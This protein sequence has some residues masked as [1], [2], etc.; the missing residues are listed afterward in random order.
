MKNS[1]TTLMELTHAYRSILKK[2]F[3]LNLG[4]VFFAGAAQAL[5]VEN[6]SHTIRNNYSY[7][8][9]NITLNNGTLNILSTLEG[10]GSG[11]QG[12]NFTLSGNTVLNL[13][14]QGPD[15]NVGLFGNNMTISGNSTW[16]FVVTGQDSY[17]NLFMCVNP[18]VWYGM[19]DHFVNLTNG[20]TWTINTEMGD[21]SD[22]HLDTNSLNLGQNSTLRATITRGD[23]H[24][25]FF[26][27]YFN[28]DQ[29]TID[30]DFTNI[31]PEQADIQNSLVKLNDAE[32]SVQTHQL[33]IP[34]T[35]NVQDSTVDLNYSDLSIEASG[36]KFYATMDEEDQQEFLDDMKRHI[37]ENDI[38]PWLAEV[39]Q[40]FD[41]KLADNITLHYD[42]I[43]NVTWTENGQSTSY[44][45]NGNEEDEED[46]SYKLRTYLQGIRKNAT[47]LKKL[48]DYLASAFRKVEGD[49]TLSG[50]TLTAKYASEIT[51]EV[52][53]RLDII[54][55][56]NITLNKGKA[57]TS[58]LS[59]QGTTGDIYVGDS[60]ITLN[61][62]TSIIRGL[63]RWTFKGVTVNPGVETSYGDVTF[64]HSKLNMYGTSFLALS[65]TDGAVRFQN[66][67]ELNIYGQNTFY[68]KNTAKASDGAGSVFIGFNEEGE[69]EN[70]VSKLNIEKGASL[71]LVTGNV[72]YKDE[73]ETYAPII[74]GD[75]NSQINIA[76]TL[77]GS[78]STEGSLKLTS[79][80]KINGQ[81]EK[82]PHI[83]LEGH[84]TDLK[85]ILGS[86]VADNESLSLS[87]VG[88]KYTLNNAIF[89]VSD[90]NETARYTE[91]VY[92]PGYRQVAFPE[93]LNMYSEED[94][95]I[96]GNSICVMGG[97]MCYTPVDNQLNTLTMTDGAALSTNKM[98]YV[99]D[100]S[101]DNKASFSTTNLFGAE[102]LTL[103]GESKVVLNAT[104]V[105]YRLDNISVNGNSEL[106]LSNGDYYLWNG[107]P[108]E[109]ALDVNNSTLTTKNTYISILSGSVSLNDVKWVD[110][111]SD[112]DIISSDATMDI[113]GD[114]N[115]TLN[116]TKA[117]VENLTVSNVD[118]K[119]P[120][121]TLNNGTTLSGQVF[122]LTNS[123]LVANNATFGVQPIGL[124]T[125][126]MY[127]D[128]TPVL[129]NSYN[130]SEAVEGIEIQ[131]S[132]VTL[133]GSSSLK[134][135]LIYV[136]EGRKITYIDLSP[137]YM[138][139]NRENLEESLDEYS[140]MDGYDDFANNI[141]INN[142]TVVLNGTASIINNSI[143][144]A[145]GKG[146]IQV[147][148]DSVI[149]A[150][151]KNTLTATGSIR[152]TDNSTLS[153][154]NGAVLNVKS[155]WDYEQ[156]TYTDDTIHL[157][158]ANLELSGT[159]NGSLDGWAKNITLSSNF[160]ING[161]INLNPESPIYGF[162][163]SGVT[164]SKAIATIIDKFN[165]TMGGNMNT[166][167]T[168]NMIDKSNLSLSGLQGVI[169]LA[170]NVNIKNNST[171]T[172]DNVDDYV[173]DFAPTQ[174]DVIDSTLKINKATICADVV[175][176][177]NSSLTATG[178][179][180][181]D[182]ADAAKNTWVTVG[183][184]F[185]MDNTDKPQTALTLTNAGLT[186]DGT[187][188]L[189]NANVKLSGSEKNVTST[190]LA[191]E[192]DI[193]VLNNSNTKATVNIAG[194]DMESYNGD[195]T[196]T[197]TTLSFAGNNTRYKW[198][199]GNRLA[200]NNILIDNSDNAKATVS[201]ST[202]NVDAD[203]IDIINT[204][205]VKM[206]DLWIN[207]VTGLNTLAIDNSKTVSLSNVSA[208]DVELSNVATVTISGYGLADLTITDSQKA[209]IAKVDVDGAT[210]TNVGNLS[211][212]DSSFEHDVGLNGAKAV[213]LDKGTKKQ[214]IVYASN[215]TLT[216]TDFESRLIVD[217]MAVTLGKGNEILGNLTLS[218]SYDAL[219][220]DVDEKVNANR[221]SVK[222]DLSVSGNVNIQQGTLEIAA[223]KKL[224][225]G[226]IFNLG[227]YSVLLL[228]GIAEGAIDGNGTVSVLNNAARIYG[229]VDLGSGELEFKNV[230]GN[231][232]TF[233]QDNLTLGNLRLTNATLTFDKNI[234]VGNDLVVE[235]S[236]LNLTDDLNVGGN[237]E[238]AD[239]KLYLKTN[240]LDV[241]GTADIYNNST[242]FIDVDEDGNYGSLRADTINLETYTSGKNAGKPTNITLSVTLP[243]AKGDN[244]ALI[245]KEYDFLDY[246]DVT[247]ELNKVTIANNR[248][249]FEETAVGQFFVT[250]TTNGKGVITRYK[251]NVAPGI[252]AA[253][254]AFLDAA[255]VFKV[256][257][258][259]A[260]ADNL[261]V[262]SQTVG[263][264][265]DYIQALSA[266]NPDDGAIV[267]TTALTTT[268][269]L[270]D[271]TASRMSTGG[272]LIG[273]NGGDVV[274]DHG[275]MWGQALYNQTKLDSTHEYQGFKGISKGTALGLEADF[276]DTIK[277]GLAYA[278]T[279]NE[280]KSDY[281][282]MDVD[283]HGVSLYGEYKPGHWFANA[284]TAF[285]W[286]DYDAKA[287]SV[288]GTTKSDFDVYTYSVQ[289]TTGYEFDL[290]KNIQ[291]VP[292]VSLRYTNLDQRS[293][294]DSDGKRINSGHSDIATLLIGN[295][296]KAS[297]VTNN[298]AKW[299]PELKVGLSYD[300][301]SDASASVVSLSNGTSYQVP[302]RRL[303]RLGATGGIGAVV[304]TGN[305]DL[306]FGYDL[307]VRKDYR[308]HTGSLKAKYH[309]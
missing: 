59:H 107:Y 294:K 162:G 131:G 85:N 91:Y 146:K 239:G 208:D 176:M 140:S 173:D 258:Q 222:E 18:F 89:S 180:T 225:T 177:E 224:S 276:A 292:S 102:Q 90:E 194:A 4:L 106:T 250:S 83:Q 109:Y 10:A 302:N 40:Q 25:D 223:R 185:T 267:Q 230:K 30:L 290:N 277:M 210:F 155:N 13:K 95:E 289:A 171:L 203:Q 245:D 5:V 158:G 65:D 218:D 104:N 118:D 215:A 58:I 128:D 227:Q 157:D 69:H 112:I 284:I 236:T 219:H 247:G 78:L 175:N 115:V 275:A 33:Y 189:N 253:A 296:F 200:A 170:S 282:K 295:D 22:I 229:D 124:E 291:T 132:T 188:T 99:R 202:G 147:F 214:K 159:L 169:D 61:D 134:N 43:N 6:S 187:I 303:K 84:K 242:I 54:D 293:Y 93:E 235:K 119:I 55:D 81:V 278:Y 204:S 94:R 248:Y 298:G 231:L 254:S 244:D 15:S 19:G 265:E 148:D 237:F 24:A 304:S 35:L 64:D 51:N 17:V 190:T 179:M 23:S 36:K 273:I 270:L 116:N 47:K 163:I 110:N 125:M 127:E 14:A 195:M 160:K 150:Q 75:E 279:Q 280:I 100:F 257:K 103:D 138:E 130:H 48:N 281:R 101:L 182:I 198:G 11:I 288:L 38:L 274:G 114:S 29:A 251:P 209:S 141:D 57:H 32:I 213:I 305:W 87:G 2:C 228:N 220:E 113:S 56:S 82:A 142:S 186:S 121:L 307:D 178:D 12:N 111:S 167:T 164:N 74:Y 76:G 98:L 201:V 165:E 9:D 135:S 301:H 286:S 41:V 300:I 105:G 212:S 120:N 97:T 241:A 70:D 143:S 183:T 233:V 122:N 268:N 172:V 226:G 249:S 53:G 72:G 184:S 37:D 63:Y 62:N 207:G 205:S 27:N 156:A 234:S 80:G 285:S 262:L 192:G 287:W 243:R 123:R 26:P 259:G 256:A 71:T 21:D 206:S 181:N 3:L 133:N 52:S 88:A 216:N 39:I 191:A 299:V 34:T 31:F 68:L 232:N 66:G 16:N 252:L 271:T 153:I 197:N 261:N 67:S 199:Q 92:D 45:W 240:T 308:S 86:N 149:R 272:T 28:A 139:K 145:G 238:M 108:I 7:Y 264:E 60:T 129:F 136:E 73:Y 174:L 269:A 211:V 255:P 266:T 221:V 49:M 96:R 283:T 79:T 196:L 263:G 260:L 77:N 217:N 42:G 126:I 144:T 8:D 306:T 154:A 151:G 161:D 297:Y 50:V 137:E 44:V 168:F 152:V 166:I 309:F 117:Y 1:K 46:F 246:N 193:Q 20:S